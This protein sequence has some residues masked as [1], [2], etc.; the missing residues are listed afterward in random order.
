VAGDG[1]LWH[2]LDRVRSGSLELPEL[3][4]LSRTRLPDGPF[5]ADTREEAERLLGA[6]DPSPA[7]RLG[8]PPDA[9]PEQLRAAADRAVRRWQ[10][11]AADPLARRAAVDAAELLVQEA[12]ALLAALPAADPGSAGGPP[13]PAA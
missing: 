7:A 11:R 10:E 4:L 5:P 8:L 3:E 12:E 9:S 6:T 2:G 13:A 1:V